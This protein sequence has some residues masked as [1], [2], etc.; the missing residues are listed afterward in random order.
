M[1]NNNDKASEVA[2]PQPNGLLKWVLLLVVGITGVGAGTAGSPFVLGTK[3]VTREEVR[4]MFRTEAPWVY[5]KGEV[6]ARIAR[7]EGDVGKLQAGEAVIR[8]KMDEA[9]GRLIRIEAALEGH[10]APPK[11][12]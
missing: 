1:E 4:D 12:N 11:G 3:G 10:R 6:L 8:Q 9:I 7:V 2:T 5:D